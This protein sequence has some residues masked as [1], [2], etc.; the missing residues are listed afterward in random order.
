MTN[1][2]KSDPPGT[3]PPYAVPSG[4]FVRF[5]NA[6]GRAFPWRDEQT[7]PFCLL[8]AEI[9]LKQ[10]RAEKV[11]KVWPE[12]VN[13]YPDAHD[14]ASANKHELFGIIAP[15]GFGN[16]RANALVDLASSIVLSGGHVPEDPETLLGLPHVGI[17]TAHAISCFAYNKRVPIVDLGIARVLSRIIGASPPQDIRRAKPLWRVAAT[18][19]PE[20]RYK[21]HNYGLLDFAAAVCKAGSP[22][23]DECCIK[24]LCIYGQDPNS[25]RNRA[26]TA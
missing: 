19:L 10:T 22:R 20:T 24:T 11:A 8:V 12:L 3:I 4:F 14:L 23:C 7:S 5:Y 2:Q 21:E 26:Y 9:A 16:Q 25:T 15:L 18:I 6:H 1:D 13:K 17:Y